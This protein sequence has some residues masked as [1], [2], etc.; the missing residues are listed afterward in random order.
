MA[1]VQRGCFAKTGQAWRSDKVEPTV[2]MDT[3]EQVIG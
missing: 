1:V 3:I 2:E